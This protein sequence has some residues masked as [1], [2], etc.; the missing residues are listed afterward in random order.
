MLS[1]QELLDWLATVD[2]KDGIYIDDGGLTLN[3]ESG[4]YIEVGGGAEPEE[5]EYWTPPNEP[6]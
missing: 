4:D 1:K 3:C 2:D 6:K 5:S